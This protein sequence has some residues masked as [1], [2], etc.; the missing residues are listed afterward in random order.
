VT[1]AICL[2]SN[3]GRMRVET[4]EGDA[5][6][7]VATLTDET[8]GLLDGARQWRADTREEAQRLAVSAGKCVLGWD[9]ST[10]NPGRVKAR[11]AK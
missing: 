10:C 2:K 1:T 9:G 8:G 3:R 7:F 5:G 4:F 6:G 11:K